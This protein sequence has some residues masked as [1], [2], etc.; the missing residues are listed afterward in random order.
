MRPS[1]S[2]DSPSARSEWRRWALDA[3]QGVNA[4]LVEILC[5]RA[6]SSD[7]AFPFPE[8][9]RRPLAA[10]NAAERLRMSRCG[11]LL[12][13]AGFSD[14]LRWRT[15][16]MP[17]GLTGPSNVA[18]AR[19]NHWL[20]GEEG[21]FLAQTTL[22]VAW[23]VLQWNRGESGV[24]LGMSKETAEAFSALGVNELSHIAQCHPDWIRPRWMQ[25]PGAW[26]D[27][28]DGAAKPVSVRAAYGALRCLQLGGGHS[29][30]LD[31]YVNARA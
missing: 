26:L 18:L 19:S 10:L 21:V 16:M 20:P 8:S 13:D 12:L 17:Q 14:P 29:R 9:V 28:L 11:V 25:L 31:S 30:W 4:Q 3:I 23:I 22:L 24:L 1:A 2:S 6:Q 27:L 15:A 7:G 5:L